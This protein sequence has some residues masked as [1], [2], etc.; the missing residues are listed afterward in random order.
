[1]ENI[2]DEYRDKEGVDQVTPE[3]VEGGRKKPF[4]S[5][6]STAVIV[7]VLFV[8]GAL[9]A[10][11]W[12]GL[13]QYRQITLNSVCQFNLKQL[14][15]VL[16]LYTNDSPGK[17]YPPAV[18]VNGIWTIDLRVLY[19]GYMTDPG[20]L[21]CDHDTDSTEIMRE[22][23]QQNPPDWDTLHRLLA[24]QY[25]YLPWAMRDE[26]TFFEMTSIDRQYADHD[27]PL[28]D[29]TLYWIRDGV[30]CIFNTEIGNPCAIDTIQ[31][32]IP[33][34]FDNPGSTNHG[35]KHINALY[36]DGHTG[37]LNLGS[38][39]FP[40]TQAVWDYFTEKT[41]ALKNEP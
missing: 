23:L 28:G 24:E 21:I 30:G 17:K 25:V 9:S 3:D 41:A 16:E 34:V 15:L 7:I 4:W 6:R 31:K 36:L 8:L 10:I 5:G 40:A 12:F 32:T 33:I 35:I 18:C 27:V 19:P 11:F 13:T 29:H 20:F 39:Q 37:F 2:T 22:A 38:N 1:M 14:S 26:K